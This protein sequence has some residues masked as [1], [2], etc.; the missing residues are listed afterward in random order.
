MTTPTQLTHLLQD[1]DLNHTQIGYLLDVAAHMKTE[2]AGGAEQQRLVGKTIAIL[3]Q[4]PS[5]RTRTAFEVAIHDQGGHCTYIDAASS[6][7]G[8]SE[9]NEDTAIVL[10]RLYA[11][12]AFRGHAHADVEALAQFASVPVWNG[13]TDEWHP[14]QALADLLT[15]REHVPKPLNRTSVCFLGY[16]R[17]NVT[18]SLLT[19]G[20]MMG[21]DIRIAC[22]DA[23]R[24][25]PAIIE[26]AERLAALSGGRVLVTSDVDAAVAG[27]DVL[28]TDVWVSM[29]DSPEEWAT[30][31]P[32]LIP[33]RID[34]AMLHRT[35]N[36]DVKFMHCLPSIHDRNSRL[37]RQLGGDYWLDGVEVAN[38]VFRSTHSIVFDQAENRMHT[39]KA[40]L[41]ASLNGHRPILA[42][43]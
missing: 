19:S 26:S 7:I 32:Q 12:I 22:P 36:P 40:V 31:I 15:I 24:P 16:A 21:M 42:V 28:Y 39:I 34:T 20:V 23:L 2:R 18:N 29:G 4:K 5:T 14:T 8:V 33:Y 38:E 3:F 35:G 25:D 43:A 30:R 17:N 27:A 37:G 6:H 41:L 9:S 10:G 13:L 1:T 11:G